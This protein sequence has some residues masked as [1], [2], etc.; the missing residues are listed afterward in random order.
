MRALFD[1]HMHAF[2]Q[3]AA[4]QAT[5]VNMNVYLGNYP[6]S[7]DNGTAYLRQKGE[8]QTALQQFGA[9]HVLGV[10][11]GNEFILESVFFFSFGGKMADLC[12]V[13]SPDKD[14]KI[15]T[16]P[17]DRKASA[18]FSLATKMNLRIAFVTAAAMLIPWINDTRSMLA[19]MGLSNITVGNA[20]AGS[21]FN[22]QVLEAV[23]YGVRIPG[24][25]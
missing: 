18:W 13:M 22:T 10:T 9:G 21:Y 19:G 8:I 6:A 24:Y 12:P 16:V 15:L 2:L 14:N 1:A 17:Q 4:I 3:L 5:G 25:I 11:V 23:D 7:D 20:D